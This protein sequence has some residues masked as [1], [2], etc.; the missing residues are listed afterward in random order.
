MEINIESPR[1]ELTQGLKHKIEYKL[2]HLQKVY[3]RITSCDITVFK[4]KDNEQK[5][6][7]IE[8]KLLLPYHEVFVK[9]EADSFDA[10]LYQLIKNLVRQV[11]D[12]KEQLQEV[13]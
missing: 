3:D 6:C 8:A 10:A 11:R 13:R 5:N 2:S 9:E 1:L 12:Y 4:Q 7:F